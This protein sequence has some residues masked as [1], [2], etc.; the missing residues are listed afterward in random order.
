[1]SRIYR[2]Y[3]LFRTFGSGPVG[4]I[5]IPISPIMPPIFEF[6]AG[7][8]RSPNNALT[9]AVLPTALLPTTSTVRESIFDA[10]SVFNTDSNAVCVVDGKLGKPFHSCSSVC[11]CQRNKTM[12]LCNKAPETLRMPI[13]NRINTVF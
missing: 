11:D 1:M 9:R 3:K 12:K 13:W 5:C 6:C 8:T 4:C 2:Q 10:R 7:M